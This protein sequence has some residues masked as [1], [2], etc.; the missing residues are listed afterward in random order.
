[1]YN[2]CRPGFSDRNVYVESNEF[3]RTAEQ[4]V[5]S[6]LGLALWLLVVWLTALLTSVLFCLNSKCALSGMSRPCRHRIK[7]GDKENYYYIS[8]SSRARVRVYTVFL[9]LFLQNHL[10]AVLGKVTFKSNALQYALLTK[11]V[12]NYVT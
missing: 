12:T 5:C 3:H 6:W 2:S 1:M 8:P 7:L 4:R 11:K 10:W 9:P